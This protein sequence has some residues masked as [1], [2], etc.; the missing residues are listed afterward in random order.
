MENITENWTTI[1]QPKTSL[2]KLN[3]RDL[4]RYRDLVRMFIVRDF[5]TFYKQTILGP[6]WFIIQPVFT[7]AMYLLI[8]GRVAKI[9]T[10][11]VPQLLFYMSGVI[12]WGYFSECLNKTA[13]TFL[14]NAG[15]FGKI[16]F[17]RLA[18]PVASVMT[19]M[20]RYGIQYVIFLVF[21]FIYIFKGV[22][23]YPNWL[24]ALTPVLLLYMAVLSMGYG[25]WIS[26]VTTKYRDLKFALPF[27]VQLWMYA[28]PVVYPLSLIPDKYKMF[29]VFNPVVPCIELFKK[30]YL[31]AGTLNPYHVAIS[32]A[33]TL[34]IFFTGIII[35][36]KTEK[37]FM[38]TV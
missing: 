24:I 23:V 33:L 31:G 16:Y 22:P 25:I 19:S 6:L 11:G 2:F 35:F 34:F 7:S 3:L 5:V 27:V 21:Y 9:S 15:I 29:M 1:I 20:I 36:N 17:P 12:N 38:D 26:A 8:F 18:V 4:W 32:G 14:A 30:A 10:D 13:D 37:T 28:T